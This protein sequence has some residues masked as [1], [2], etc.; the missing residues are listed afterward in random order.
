[1]QI[2]N[3]QGSRGILKADADFQMI[4]PISLYCLQVLKQPAAALLAAADEQHMCAAYNASSIQHEQS[5][6]LDITLDLIRDEKSLHE[7]LLPSA[8]QET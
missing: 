1:M 2:A 4:V 8:T 3:I 7:P 5:V 6:M